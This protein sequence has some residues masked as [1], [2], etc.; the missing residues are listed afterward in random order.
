MTRTRP[1]TSIEAS[2]SLAD[3]AARIKA[4]H[5]A[6]AIALRRGVEHAIAAGAHW[7]E[8]FNE[9]NGTDDVFAGPAGKPH[10]IPPWID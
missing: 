6:T 4:E 1:I 7:I 5:E 2:N 9:W 10:P 3:L 8:A